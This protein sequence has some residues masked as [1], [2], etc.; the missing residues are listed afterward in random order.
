VHGVT[1]LRVGIIG[2]GWGSLV[3]APAFDVAAGYQVVGLCS[4]N[5]DRVKA[6]GQK[7]GISSTSTNWREFI[8]RDD[9]DVVAVCTP[10]PLHHDQ[11]VGA[12]RAGKHVLCEKPVA[13]DPEQARAMYEL[14]ADTGLVSAVNFEGRWL[15]ERLPVWEMV[16]G[17]YLGA[18]YFGRVVTSADFWH[19]ARGLQSEWMYKR[20]EGGGYLLGL[21]SHDIDYLAALFGEPV[22]VCAD[23]A[24]TL[25]ERARPD[26][27]TLQVTADDTS[28][29]LLRMSSGARCVISTTTT[30]TLTD[31]RTLEAY[32]S[33]GSI[34][35]DGHVQ[36]VGPIT[37]IR[38]GQ[39]G[40]EALAPVLLSQREP[41][42]EV[43]IPR[44]RAG[45][46]IR[47][48]SLML[49]DWLPAF[50]GQSTKVP[51]LRQGWVVARVVQAAHLSSEGAGWVDIR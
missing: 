34:V 31:S 1:D 45:E 25:K 22:A 42:S 15:R 49:E 46:A 19:P 47:A 11:T 18:P 4:R 50:D 14:A 16:A 40:D 26:G 48:L 12:L 3:L 17:G 28:T 24:T 33:A 21:A 13:L 23:V 27:T 39:V 10:T 51:D 43:E 41:R 32:G 30:A 2:V 38:A 8:A 35:V 37:R 9:I 44:R 7:L 6:A 29:L 36:G 5:A 20:D